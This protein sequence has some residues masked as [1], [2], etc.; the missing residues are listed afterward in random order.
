M[1]KVSIAPSVKVTAGMPGVKVRK[2]RNKAALVL[3]VE[4]LKG[5]GTYFQ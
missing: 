1:R 5:L 2:P 3:E 4:R